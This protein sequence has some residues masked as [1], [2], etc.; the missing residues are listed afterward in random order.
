MALP[1]DNL[2]NPLSRVPSD[3]KDQEAMTRAI[4]AVAQ[5]RAALIARVEKHNK[6]QIADNKI[7]QAEEAFER[8][9][10]REFRPSVAGGEGINQTTFGIGNECRLVG[11][12]R[13]NTLWWCRTNSPTTAPQT[14]SWKTHLMS[15][16]PMFG[17]ASSPSMPRFCRI[18]PHW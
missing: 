3:G 5:I 2:T 17:I 18:V 8:S 11:A 10:P 16:R 7:W 12:P 4:D 15:I 9:P 1:L 13:R 6:W 14:E